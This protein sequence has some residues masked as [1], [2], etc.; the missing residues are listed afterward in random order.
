M[1]AQ[2]VLIGAD[3]LDRGAAWRQL[4]A[5]GSDRDDAAGGVHRGLEPGADGEWGAEF[6]RE[7]DEVAVLVSPVLWQR[8]ELAGLVGG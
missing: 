8:F 1:R 6:G 4:P 5:A 2:P 3:R 7:E